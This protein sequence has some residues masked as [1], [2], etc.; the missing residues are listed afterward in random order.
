MDS[1]RDLLFRCNA[2]GGGTKKSRRAHCRGG[3][4]LVLLWSLFWC[5]FM[6]CFGRRAPQHGREQ[7][8][9]RPP[10]L[11]CSRNEGST[12][13]P[14]ANGQVHRARKVVEDW[15]QLRSGGWAWVVATGRPWLR[16]LLLRT[17]TPALARLLPV[18]HPPQLTT[19][20]RRDH[21]RQPR[22]A[23]QQ[24]HPPLPGCSQPSLA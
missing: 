18:E 7:T 3:S 5:L 17:G 20:R 11:G 1:E 24:L 22:V 23:Q 2:G 6:G 13:I 21:S 19:T 15:V 9:S 16:R 8:A 10:S 14:D 4:C 12:A